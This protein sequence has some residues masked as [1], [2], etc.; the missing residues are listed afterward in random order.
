MGCS[1]IDIG[2]MN[3]RVSV[4]SYS[5]TKHAD[6]KEEILVYTTVAN[7]W[8]KVEQ[9]DR[10][11]FSESTILTRE[12]AEVRQVVTIRYMALL[13]DQ[14]NRLGIDGVTY[15]IEGVN[16]IGNKQYM[17]LFCIDLT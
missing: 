9:P 11:N 15:D 6:T 1:G 7:V 8:A 10:T 14:K 4:L 13:N 12:T 2:Q 17:K 3:R 5:V 16:V